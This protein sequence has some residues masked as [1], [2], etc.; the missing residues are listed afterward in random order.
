MNVCTFVWRYFNFLKA[1]SVENKSNEA[2]VTT[3]SLICEA[4]CDRQTDRHT[5]PPVPAQIPVL[6]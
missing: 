6:A 5:H 2:S 3:F 1:C 4:A